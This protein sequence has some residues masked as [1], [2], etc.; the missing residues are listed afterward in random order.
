[1][2]ACGGYYIWESKGEDFI[3]GAIQSKIAA[4][5][6]PAD[7]FSVDYKNGSLAFYNTDL[8][9]F[10]F[11]E[12]E[13]S[14]V[15]S[16]P[17]IRFVG[18]DWMT[19]NA[20]GRLRADT[21]FILADSLSFDYD[22]VNKIKVVKNDMISRL[23]C[24]K[25]LISFGGS[26]FHNIHSL[27]NAEVLAGTIEVDDVSYE[28]ENRDIAFENPQLKVD[29]KDLVYDGKKVSIDSIK[30]SQGNANLFGV[31]FR[32]DGL[33]ADIRSISV[34]ADIKNLWTTR[35]LDEVKIV[36]N[37]LRIPDDVTE[38]FQGNDT[39]LSI[40]N[41][42]LRSKSMSFYSSKSEEKIAQVSEVN[43][44][45]P[46]VKVDKGVISY[47]NFDVSGVCCECR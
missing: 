26:H 36:A 44:T 6:F 24:D 42:E 39:G 46:K 47:Q 11:R 9:T 23:E 5:E 22:D 21:I 32:Q 8:E 28:I 37:S 20:T 29:F 25:L 15:I 10:L 12:Q 45:L 43:A 3:E 7:S 4:I 27:T 35:D 17:L 34:L 13:T 31:Y 14:N 33:E 40:K 1:L 2:L 18:L 38:I 30:M 19:I 41:F 16:V